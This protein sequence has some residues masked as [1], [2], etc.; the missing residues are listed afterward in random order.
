MAPSLRVQQTLYEFKCS[1]VSSYHR[2]FP[3]LWSRRK[4]WMW[5]SIAW[6]LIRFQPMKSGLMSLPLNLLKKS[7]NSV[8]RLIG[9]PSAI[10]SDAR[11]LYFTSSTDSF[12]VGMS[13]VLESY[14]GLYSDWREPGQGHSVSILQYGN[15][16]GE[17]YKDKY[18]GC[19]QFQRKHLL[20]SSSKDKGKRKEYIN[21]LRIECYLDKVSPHLNIPSEYDSWDKEQQDAWNHI[22]DH[23]NEYY[24]HYLLPGLINRGDEWN[25]EEKEEFVFALR[26]SSSR[27]ALPLALPS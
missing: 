15:I 5:Q 9:M 21:C 8:A 3:L 20:R 18:G 22:P 16:I 23:A 1:I 7:W 10:V 25:E 4:S 19:F 24:Y 13:T 11:S 27:S 14:S 17:A 6:C 12:L 2:C 26:V